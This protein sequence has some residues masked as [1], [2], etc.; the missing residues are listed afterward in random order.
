[1]SFDRPYVANAGSGEFIDREL[2][3][4]A[5][6]ERLGLPLQYVTDI[7]LHQ[8]PSAVAGA[9]AIV[10]MGHDEY[11]SP[12][13]RAAL[14][15]ARDGGTNLAFFGA[16]AVFRRIR[17]AATSLG[18]DRLEVN[19]K[20]A[21]EDPLDAVNSP[22]TTADWPS[23]PH[24]DPES[25]LI[26]AQYACF[27][28]PQR[29]AGVVA[30]PS[31]WVFAGTG[32]RRGTQLPGLVGPEID[33][34]QLQYPTP[35]PIDVLLHSPDTCAGAPAYAD[36]TYY[37][38][39]SGAGVF[40]AGTIDWACDAGGGC[41]ASGPTGRVVRTVTDNV[42]RAFATSRAGWLHPAHDD[43]AALGLG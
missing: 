39:P 32:V 10:S 41:H 36:A 37:V 9:A 28:G 27:P 19:Y 26:G 11:Y 18:P 12:A 8:H 16:N 35:R 4:L 25:S 30:D 1:V 21:A 43:L 23:P 38:A 13:M 14:T 29:V 15:R 24:P 20:I 33:A 2:P 34:V 3:V 6:A 42:L 5:Q 31:S 7:D 40:D 22:R 17:L